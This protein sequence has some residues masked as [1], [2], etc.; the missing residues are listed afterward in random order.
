MEAILKMETRTKRRIP[1]GK[2]ISP[3]EDSRIHHDHRRLP[4][5]DTPAYRASY[6]PEACSTQELLAAIIGG[7]DHTQAAFELL[8]NH[9][10]LRVMSH[11]SV[12]ELARIPGI[13]L[14]KAASIRA[15]LELGRRTNLPLEDMPIIQSPE[16]AAEI[17]MPRMGHLEEE[18]LVVLALN[19]R[20]RLIGEPIEIY[21]GT[22]NASMVRVGEVFRPALKANAA[23]MIV[24]HNH[25][26]GEVFP[27]PEDVALT[28]VIVEA[29][30]ILEVQLLDHLVIGA[31]KYLSLKARGLGF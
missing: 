25:P 5:R 8:E 9:K 12:Q 27:S 21:N 24:A 1:V 4:L 18:R 19:T 6:T 11:A 13:G 28:R 3:L 16:D 7:E 30:K 31:N 17:L 15:A 23:A 2:L 14:A 22:L 10:D 20:N 26:S 29:G